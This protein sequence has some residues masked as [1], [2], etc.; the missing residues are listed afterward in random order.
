MGIERNFL[1]SRLD[2]RHL[3]PTAS[4][5]RHERPAL[6]SMAR[7]LLRRVSGTVVA[8]VLRR[9]LQRDRGERNLPPAAA[10]QRLARGRDAT[11]PNFRL[12]IRANHH[13][14]HNRTLVDPLPSIRLEHDA[15]VRQ[16]EA[17]DP[18]CWE[19]ANTDLV[20]VCLQSHTVTC[21]PRYAEVQPQPCGLQSFIGGAETFSSADCRG[22]MRARS[23]S[24][25]AGNSITSSALNTPT[26]A[27]RAL[28]FPAITAPDVHAAVM[29]TPLQSSVAGT[30]HRARP[31]SKA[32]R[33]HRGDR[34]AR[35]R[36]Y[37]SACS[38]S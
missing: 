34:R 17:A 8:G 15:V 35:R 33:P 12:A 30:R 24:S 25:S 29:P 38:L 27:T 28:H 26:C 31:K 7:E 36:T 5:D 14:T 2:A 19:R 3:V 22:G 37:F 18:P 20:D 9:V 13:L 23:V 4:L 32:R 11:P 6:A 21:V 1:H 10:R 16:S